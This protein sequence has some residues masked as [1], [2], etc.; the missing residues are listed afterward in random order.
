MF[1]ELSVAVA[2]KLV[3]VSSDTAAGRPGPANVAAL[4][5]ASIGPEQSFVE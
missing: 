3:V 5:D 2:L 1:P 4:P